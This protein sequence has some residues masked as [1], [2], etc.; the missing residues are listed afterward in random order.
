MG[1]DPMTFPFDFHLS[2]FPKG[3]SCMFVG[4]MK[5]WKHHFYTIA[6]FLLLF[7]G[8]GLHYWATRM[9]TRRFNDFLPDSFSI[10]TRY[11]MASLRWTEPS[12]SNATTTGG[13]N[14]LDLIRTSR[15]GLDHPEKFIELTAAARST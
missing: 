3:S 14:H 2:A 5:Q 8:Q 10:G 12:N 6:L 9:T 4:V 15:G 7:T 11:S 1:F 13:T